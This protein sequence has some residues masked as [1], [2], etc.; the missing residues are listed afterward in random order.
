MKWLIGYLMLEYVIL[1]SS[2]L[3]GYDD[4]IYLN[5]K[6]IGPKFSVSY[7]LKNERIIHDEWK[8][9]YE[10]KVIW[11]EETYSDDLAYLTLVI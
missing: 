8:P 3:L 9:Y 4:K 7:L 6:Q 10:N 2:F 5:L 1:Y 11:I